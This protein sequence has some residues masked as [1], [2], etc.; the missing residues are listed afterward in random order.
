MHD[1]QDCAHRPR[2]RTSAS[3]RAAHASAALLPD[4]W[5]SRRELT[6]ALQLHRAECEFLTGELVAAEKRLT[7]LSFH[8]ADPVEQTTVACLGVDLY[9]TLARSDSAVAVCLDTY[10]I[11]AGPIV[12][13]RIGGL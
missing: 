7:A 11:P 2:S 6:F 5:D 1:A 9:T 3:G 13:I 10:E 8:A 4:C 12:L